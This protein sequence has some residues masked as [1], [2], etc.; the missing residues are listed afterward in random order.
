MSDNTHIG[1]QLDVTVA[2]LEQV[3]AKFR[4]EVAKIKAAADQGAA[5]AQTASSFRA[6]ASGVQSQVSAAAAAEPGLVAKYGAGST[7]VLGFQQALLDLRRQINLTSSSF[8]GA[9][10]TIGNAFSQLGKTAPLT[11]QQRT[12]APAFETK[13]PF[14]GGFGIAGAKDFG[15]KPEGIGGELSNAQRKLVKSLQAEAEA[16]AQGAARLGILANESVGSR[17]IIASRAESAIFTQQINAQLQQEIAQDNRLAVAKA[18]EINARDRIAAD[19]ARQQALPANVQAH[20][21][22]VTEQARTGVEQRGAVAAATTTDDLRAAANVNFAERV[23][24]AAQKAQESANLNTTAGQ[25]VLESEG[26]TAAAFKSQAALVERVTQEALAVDESY[27]TNTAEAATARRAQA[28]RVTLSAAGESAAGLGGVELEARAAVVSRAEADMRAAAIARATGEAEIEAGVQRRIAESQLN[29]AI[30]IR[31]RAILKEAIASGELAGSR[32]QLFQARFSGAVKAPEDYSTVGNI[33][34]GKLLT[35]AG[36]G[37]AAAAVFGG[38]TEIKKMLSESQKLEVVLTQVKDVLRSTG[39]SNSFGRVK[40]DVQSIAHETG[41]AADAVALT[42]VRFRGMSGDTDKALVDTAAAMKLAKVAGVDLSNALEPLIA[43]ENEFGVSVTDV[44]DVA[45]TANQRFGVSVAGITQA[46]GSTAA[47]AAAAGA[48]G[49]AGLQDMVSVLATSANT[50]GGSFQQTEQQINRFLPALDTARD[51]ILTIYRQTPALAAQYENVLQSFAH[52]RSFDVFKQIAT[53]FQ[54]LN[55][56]QRL[57]LL[58]AIANRR[59]A[60]QIYAILQSG[61]LPQQFADNASGA[62]DSTGALQTRFQSLGETLTNI[63]QR[64]NEAF[65]QIGDALVN[66]GIE[67]VLKKAA[68]TAELVANALK[69]VFLILGDINNLSKQILP[70]IPQGTLVLLGELYLAYLGLNKVLGALGVTRLGDAAATDVEVAA[71]QKAY[72]ASVTEAEGKTLATEATVAH[73]GAEELDVAAI[74][75]DTIALETEGVALGTNAAARSVTT[76]SNTAGAGS[77]LSRV[78][79]G[80]SASGRAAQLASQDAAIGG[81]TGEAGAVGAGAVGAGASSGLA[82]GVGGLFTAGGAAAVSGV[83]AGTIAFIGAAVVYQKVADEGRK[84]HE[85]SAKLADKLSKASDAQVEAAASSANL[86]NKTR[87]FLDILADG[88]TRLMGNESPNDMVIAEYNRR[89]AAPGIETTQ[90]A[91]D[92]GLLGPVL[93]QLNQANRQGLEDFFKGNAQKTRLGREVGLLI[94]GQVLSID[95]ETPEQREARRRYGGNGAGGEI[96]TGRAD[97]LTTPPAASLGLETDPQKMADAYTK[98]LEKAKN[99]DV[100]AEEALNYLRSVIYGQADL[101]TKSAVIKKLV[102]AGQQKAAADIAGGQGALLSLD[103]AEAKQNLDAGKI[104]NRQYLDIIQKKVEEYQHRKEVDPGAFADKDQAELDKNLKL[105]ADARGQQA[106]DY[107]NSLQTTDILAGT[108][109]EASKLQSIIGLL[110]N[111]N[112]TDAQRVTQLAAANQQLQTAFKEKLAL[113]IDPV[114]RYAAMLD[115]FEIPLPVQMMNLATTLENS[116]TGSKI[117]GEFDIYGEQTKDFSS[118]VAK[119]VVEGNM[120]IRD[121][122]LKVIDDQIAALQGIPWGEMSSGNSQADVDAVNTQI[123]G[124]QGLRQRIAAMA[125]DAGTGAAAV[126]KGG[127]DAASLLAASNAAVER[128]KALQ[129]GYYDY[130]AAVNAGNPEMLAS[131]AAL[132]AQAS[133]TAARAMNNGQGDPLAIQAAQTEAV[134]AKNQAFAAALAITKANIALLKA[135]ADGDPDKQNAADLQAAYADLNDAARRND[136]AGIASAQAALTT[137]RQQNEANQLDKRKA[138]LELQAAQDADDPVKAAR[139]AQQLAALQMEGAKGEAA[140]T[141]AQVAQTA[142]NRALN[143]ANADIDKANLE[144]QAARDANDPVKAARDAQA[145]AD[146]QAKT[147]VGEAAKIRAAAA[148]VAADRAL[149]LAIQDVYKSQADLLIAIADAAGLTVKA[150]ELGLAEAKRQLEALKAQGAGESAINAGKAAVVR[151][152]AAAR[153]AEYND[154]L[155]TIDFLLQI[156]NITTGQ[157]IAMLQAMQ[158]IPNLTE[159]EL[160]DIQLKIKSLQQSLSAD[161]QFNLPTN[162]DLPTAYEARRV[163]QS[164]GGD[165]YDQRQIT[166]TIIVPTGTSVAEIVAI[167]DSAINPGTNSATGTKRY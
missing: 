35:T 118:R 158:Q 126:D 90:A 127:A 48:T 36:Y 83:A 100:G 109:T 38:F 81:I 11:A 69:G 14:M 123:A 78:G 148:R 145:M 164:G 99:G 104:S 95:S 45:V 54:S 50:A 52:G 110:Q 13:S 155:G 112:L 55:Q 31:E 19:L 85:A 42:F 130:L 16:A 89:A 115:G 144:L 165:N 96:P 101:A 73:T 150:A 157:A 49:K 21:E 26:L 51:K 68:S 156:G 141:R 24:K 4:A 113:I 76:A 93:G 146:Q 22:R 87:G 7:E 106:I 30:K 40:A 120:T 160:R 20:A 131:L 5:P 138:L 59:E 107:A 56:T 140:K 167:V 137:V 128:T 17:G 166:T 53:D 97:T 79:F 125:P 88:F 116:P 135:Q 121:A 63:G 46:V 43:A 75:L 15:I 163:V 149:E 57:Q 71:S 98:L 142:A 58:H 77:I 114:A 25:A 10:T 1:I 86:R 102:E 67:D 60:S 28:A 80:V 117:A 132:K 129:V 12:L 39:D 134:A 122:Y 72:V 37:I 64:L 119:L 62:N 70:F 8:A 103:F 92:S 94:P 133:M 65:K 44:G 162:I 74:E 111:P 41:A 29:A 136:K 154:R 151:A 18:A 143:A 91:V 34:G 47:A 153:D 159:K 147:A 61:A 82:S 108:A 66:A 105:L 32:T 33:V 2:G 3:A 139:D 9:N 27:I 23:N 84:L 152:E 124:L 161:F 6:A